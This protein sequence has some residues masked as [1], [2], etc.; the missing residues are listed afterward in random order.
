MRGSTPEA[1]IETIRANGVKL[2]CL[3]ACSEANSKAAAPSF[4]PDELPAVTV[5]SFLN[6]GFNL[7]NPSKVVV[8]FTNSSLSNKTGSPFF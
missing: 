6:D 1:P 8:G 5:P 3:I 2:C 4:N 7:A